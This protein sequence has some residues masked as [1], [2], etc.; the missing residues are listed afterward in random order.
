MRYVGLICNASVQVV[1]SGNDHYYCHNYIVDS[2]WGCHLHLG[3]KPC[4]VGTD[5]ANYIQKVL[6]NTLVLLLVSKQ[7]KLYC[8]R[9]FSWQHTHLI[10]R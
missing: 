2:C 3:P 4:T 10:I 6:R 8:W 1:L 7:F 9:D 5:S